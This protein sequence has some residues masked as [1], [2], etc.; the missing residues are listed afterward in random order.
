MRSEV[1][2][3]AAHTSCRSLDKG[4][5]QRLQAASKADVEV[6]IVLSFEIDVHAGAAYESSAWHGTASNDNT[7]RGSR[8][9][10]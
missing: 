1:T 4:F 5:R 3:P 2:V 10:L 7:A 9:L 6:I 8:D